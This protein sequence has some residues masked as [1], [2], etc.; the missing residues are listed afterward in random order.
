[1]ATSL[2]LVLEASRRRRTPEFRALSRGAA[3]SLSSHLMDPLAEEV[4][5]HEVSADGLLF[6]SRVHGVSGLLS[7]LA[8]REPDGLPAE[9]VAALAAERQSIGERGKRLLEDLGALGGVA[10]RAGLPLIPLKGAYL[11]SERYRDL[12]LRPAADI[13]LL[14]PGDTFEPWGRLLVSEGYVLANESW[15]NRVY[16]RPGHR[17]PAGFGEHP[18]NPRP[19]ELHQRVRE[20]FLGRTIDFTDVLTARLTDGFVGGAIAARLPD[21]SALALHLFAHAAPAAIGRGLRLIQLVDF[22]HLSTRADTA[23]VLQERLGEAAWGLAALIEKGLPGALPDSLR[24]ALAL[25]PP[26]PRRQRLWLSRPGLMTGDEEK[27]ILIL[28]ELRLTRDLPSA[29]GRM[30][31]AL[32]DRAVLQN[33]Y[34]AG[35]S[36]ASYLNALARYCRDR[37]S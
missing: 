8:D 29:A 5:R 37:F 32:P 12:S 6:A 25:A 1:M 33:L 34:G 19:V 3:R 31:D 22:S 14:A 26:S 13:D 27:T 24:A 4:A 28:A 7:K 16:V 18:D 23:G 30:A 36:G 9:H 15:K 35:A 11:A 10:R 20:R 17:E 2:P 21:D